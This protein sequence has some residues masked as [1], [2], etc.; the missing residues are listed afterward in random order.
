MTKKCF[1]LSSSPFSRLRWLWAALQSGNVS[2]GTFLSSPFNSRMSSEACFLFPWIWIRPEQ[3]LWLTSPEKVQEQRWW[4]KSCHGKPC[5]CSFCFHMEHSLLQVKCG[6]SCE[7]HQTLVNFMKLMWNT[8]EK[9]MGLWFL[10]NVVLFPLLT[11]PVLFQIPSSESAA[12]FKE[13]E[14]ERER[15]LQTLGNIH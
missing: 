11:K 13:R 5:E 15:E 12:K 6:N 9:K 14:R 3:G 2:W 4:R 10:G 7:L 8:T 1:C